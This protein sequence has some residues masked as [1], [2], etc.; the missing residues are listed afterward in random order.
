MG[1]GMIKT[2]FIHKAMKNRDSNVD[3]DDIDKVR[4]L[5]GT[6]FD[7]HALE[8]LQPL[9][10]NK[11]TGTLTRLEQQQFKSKEQI[12]RNY[13]I[14][15]PDLTFTH[16]DNQWVAEIDGDVHWQNS[17]S[18]K[19]TNLRNETYETAGIKMLWFTRD[20]VRKSTVKD[21]INRMSNVLGMEIVL[22]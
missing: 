21:L 14:F 20:E 11:L 1:I 3:V 16:R 17:K 22:K 4:R 19:R 10:F 13:H 5:L 6:Y 18:V 9:F 12:A 7:I 15:N 2:S 8:P